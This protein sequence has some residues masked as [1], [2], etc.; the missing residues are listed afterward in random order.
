MRKAKLNDGRTITLHTTFQEKLNSI[1]SLEELYGFANR[2]KVLGADLP[3]WSDD[4]RRLILARKHELE[5][6][7]AK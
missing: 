1:H 3:K 7:N 5:K 6:Q 4:E 2:R